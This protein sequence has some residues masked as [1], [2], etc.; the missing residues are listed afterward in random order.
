MQPRSRSRHNAFS[1]PSSINPQT[2]WQG[3]HWS[4]FINIQGLII[5]LRRFELLVGQQDFVRAKIEL[6]TATELM[7]ASSASMI[8]AGSFSQ[9]EYESQVREMMMPPYVV[10]ANFSGLMSWEH[11]A[12]IQVWKRL[13]PVFGNL[14]EMLQ[15]EH[16]QFIDAYAHL[17]NSHRAVCAKFGGDRSGSLR[18]KDDTAL[19]TLDKFASRRQLLINP[20]RQQHNSCPFS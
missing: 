9:Q 7:L 18:C 14:P 5:C 2:I 6:E 17:A 15:P 12:L 16:Q 20:N 13:R 1:P 3:F 11:S 10:S 4:F 8:L 19:N